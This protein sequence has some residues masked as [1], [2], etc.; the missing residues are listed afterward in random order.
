MLCCSRLHDTNLDDHRYRKFYDYPML[1]DEQ[2]YK[3]YKDTL[4]EAIL[5]DQLYRDWKSELEESGAD[6]PDRRTHSEVPT[7]I[8]K[9]I[10]ESQ[11]NLQDKS[12]CVC[13]LSLAC[14]RT[15]IKASCI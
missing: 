14:F 15:L 4:R 5:R 10:N 7:R 8:E 6:V 2:R 3:Y 11:D 12:K 13:L 1:T 9:T